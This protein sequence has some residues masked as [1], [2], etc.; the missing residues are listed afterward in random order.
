MRITRY[1]A[2]A[3][4][5]AFVLLSCTKVEGDNTSGTTENPQERIITI[6]YAGTRTAVD[7][8]AV[9]FKVGD[10]IML[11]DALAD[12]SE[13]VKVSEASDGT[14][15]LSTTLTGN[16]EAV[17][18]AKYAVVNGNSLTYGVPPV[19][20]GRF[21][22]ADICKATGITD[23]ADFTTQV[24]ILR[25]YVDESIGVSKIEIEGT[26]VAS[27]GDKITIE[28]ASGKTLYDV[29]GSADKRI[30]YAAVCPVSGKDI[31]LT[32][33]A[34]NSQVQTR[35]IGSVSLSGGYIY[36]AFIP[37]YIDLGDAGKWG[38]CNIGAFLPEDSGLFFA[39]GEVAGHKNYLDGYFHFAEENF[40]FSDDRYKNKDAS[41]GFFW[42]NTPYINCINYD[43]LLD[44]ADLKIDKYCFS[45]SEEEPLWATYQDCTFDNTYTLATKQDD[46][47]YASWGHSWRMPTKEEYNKLVNGVEYSEG[48]LKIDGLIIPAAGSGLENTYYSY[49]IFYWT[50][51]LA[52]DYGYF[53]D[54][55]A[56]PC[57]AFSLQYIDEDY[58]LGTYPDARYKGMPIRPIWGEAS[59]PDEP[60]TNITGGSFDPMGKIYF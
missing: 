34:A 32:G 54:E 39:W 36:N 27:D 13:V 53:P 43:S 50:S 12:E 1:I 5:S 37:Y 33:T 3:A 26:G 18:P 49:G 20:T 41:K 4:M 11:Y 23:N 45:Y 51:S 28:A 15:F 2:M 8:L 29:G 38:Y 19:Q 60:D 21:E 9:T 56:E 16:L 22:D 17:Y 42:Y 35:E 46:A 24:S 52:K 58:P 40:D 7:G 6:S 14:Q 31:T 47:A 59:E 57:L 25:F 55:P 30:C 48:D 44:L 10:E